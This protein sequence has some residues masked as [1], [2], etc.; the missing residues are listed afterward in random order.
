MIL[1]EF[2][3]YIYITLFLLGVILSFLDFCVLLYNYIYFYIY[4]IL[5]IISPYYQVS[6]GEG[7]LRLPWHRSGG[8][9]GPAPASGR[10]ASFTF[11]VVTYV[12][13][14]LLGLRP[15]RAPAMLGT[16][17]EKDDTLKVLCCWT[18]L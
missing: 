1:N 17:V 5:G 7:P 10:S 9:S 18:P 13:N 11:T 8:A 15:L 12:D 2:K 4:I 14:N 3:K 16:T 6:P